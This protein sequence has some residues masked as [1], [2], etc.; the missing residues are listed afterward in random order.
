MK[1]KFRSLYLIFYFGLIVSLSLHLYYYCY[2]I[3]IKSSF[4][5]ELIGKF[6][7]LNQPTRTKIKTNY[8]QYVPFPR[9]NGARFC[10]NNLLVVFKRPANMAESALAEPV[11]QKTL[12]AYHEMINSKI[13]ALTSKKRDK[14]PSTPC[15]SEY[16]YP[17]STRTRQTR[18]GH[19]ESNQRSHTLPVVI[20]DIS[21]I[22]PVSCRELAG[23]Y[24]LDPGRKLHQ[25]CDI[26]MNLAKTRRRPG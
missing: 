17:T 21:R 15:V 7:Q 23:E 14:T 9:I 8:D 25:I 5:R 13:T 19:T 10:S 18:V 26:N 6:C 2:V 20:S 3:R 11:R 12:R 1:C 16:Y 22:L 24:C 4:L